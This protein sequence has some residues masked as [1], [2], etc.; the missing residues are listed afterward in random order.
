MTSTGRCSFSATHATVAVFPVPVAPSSTM[1]FSPARIR[2]SISA[3]AVGWSPA[4][5]MSVTTRNGATFR[6]RSV[7]GR[8]APPPPSPPLSSGG[9]PFQLYGGGLTFRAG[10]ETVEQAA[11]RL[12]VVVE[13]LAAL[14]GKGHRGLAR[15]PVAGLLGADVAG[16]LELAQV[17]DEVA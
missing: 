2:L 6:C 10:L 1:S 13:R 8:T 4:G 5:T 14:A 3:I 9:P 7:T 12:G 17:G 11:Q 16:V 15:G